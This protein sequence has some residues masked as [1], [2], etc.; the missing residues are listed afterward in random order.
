M[1]PLEDSSFDNPSSLS[2]SSPKRKLSEQQ[3]KAVASKATQRQS[4]SPDAS[5]QS[6]NPFSKRL[7]TS[8]PSGNSMRSE[9]MSKKMGMGSGPQ[10]IDLTRPS[11]FQ[12]NTGAKRLVIKNLRTTSRQDS[13]EYYQRTWNDI[14]R[15]LTEIF[16]GR[17]QPNLP[18]E[19]LCRGV[20]VTC[21]HARAEKLFKH[22][23]ERCKEYLDN[24]LLH[25][26]CKDVGTSNIDALRAVHRFWTIWNKQSVREASQSER[27]RANYVFTGAVAVHIQLS[28][29]IVSPECER[30]SSTRRFGNP[31]IPTCRFYKD[32]GQGRPSSWRESGICHV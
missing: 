14:D 1:P 21:R 15:A 27:V 28:R 11:N 19:V 24:K 18:L 4:P 25:Q 32:Q 26:I 16:D 12:P 7:K 3:K 13:D 20:E 22:Y 8:H 6:N 10:V 17:P 31:T 23:K 2:K 5:S 9:D 29:S 30:P